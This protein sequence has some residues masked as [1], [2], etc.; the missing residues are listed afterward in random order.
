MVSWHDNC[1][2]FYDMS[3]FT[4]R[5]DLFQRE[6]AISE[7]LFPFTFKRGKH[8]VKHIRFDNDLEIKSKYYHY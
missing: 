4:Q 5:S 2:S 7:L 8:I 6:R 3:V 1:Q